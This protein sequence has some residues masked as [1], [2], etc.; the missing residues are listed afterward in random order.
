[1]R[2]VEKFV[3]LM[4]MIIIGKIENK[5]FIRIENMMN[6]EKRRELIEIIEIGDKYVI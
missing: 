1:M 3:E 2:E 4:M 6:V 5:N